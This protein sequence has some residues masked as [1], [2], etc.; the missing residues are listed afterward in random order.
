MG[1]PLQAEPGL[2]HGH[3]DHA[4]RRGCTGVGEGVL[5]GVGVWGQVCYAEG[6]RFSSWEVSD[7]VKFSGRRSWGS[8]VEGAREA[9]GAKGEREG[10]WERPG[11][12]GAGPGQGRRKGN[13]D[14]GH[15]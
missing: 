3:E 13:A 14:G 9:V 1:D 15:F 2:E 11:S 10:C 6:L 5:D 7:M 12:R 8:S 4:R